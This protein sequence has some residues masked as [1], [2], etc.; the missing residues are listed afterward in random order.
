[1]STSPPQTASIPLTT[2][3]RPPFLRPPTPKNSEP[4][5]AGL[6]P[7]TAPHRTL[8]AVPPLPIYLDVCLPGSS[9]SISIVDVDIL[10]AICCISSASR[11]Q[12]ASRPAPSR[13]IRCESRAP[14]APLSFVY[15]P[16]SPARPRQTLRC[17]SPRPLPSERHFDFSRNVCPIDTTPP[18][19]P[20]IS[21][22][23]S[24]PPPAKATV[25]H[26]TR[27][28][29]E[30]KTRTALQT[31]R[32][33]PAHSRSLQNVVLSVSV[34]DLFEKRVEKENNRGV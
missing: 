34:L 19:R 6:A 4:A 25:R 3:R 16:S 1:M 2:H 31:R 32:I 21:I 30:E 10:L 11:P 33:H 26:R 17:I 18:R 9:I 27:K 29:T 5:S 22:S 24:S 20:L 28:R 13:S 15:P 12:S 14:R 23:I 7:R 8:H